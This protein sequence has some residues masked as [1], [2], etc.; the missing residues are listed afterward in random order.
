MRCLKMVGGLVALVAAVL[1]TGELRAVQVLG[2]GTAALLRGDL[3]DIDDDGVETSYFPPDNYGGFD[4]AFF[5]SDEPGFGGG[6]SAFNVFDNVVGGG[7]DKW[8]C[9]TVF[10]QIVGADFRDAQGLAFRLT[11]FTVSSAN[12]TPDRDPRIWRIDGS[13]DGESWCPIFSPAHLADAVDALGLA[14]GSAIW[15]ARGQVILF[16]EGVD[17][18]EQD[19]AYSMFRMVTLKTNLTTGAFFQIS[20]IEFFGEEDEPPV[21][22]PPCEECS[23]PV[24]DVTCE[25]GG[26]GSLS[27]FWDNPENCACADETLLFIK[28]VEVASVEAS[29]TSATIPAGLLPACLFAAVEVRNCSFISAICSPLKV[30]GTGTAALLGD[31]LGGDL[32]DVGNDGVEGSYFPPDNYGG[33]DADFFSSDEPGF[34]GGEFAFNVFDNIVGGGND[35]W[36]CGTVFP[37]IVGADFS[38]TF[39]ATQ[40]RL[41][42]FTVASANDTPDRDPRVWR[43]EGSNDG[44]D[45]TTIFS[46]ECDPTA[47]LWTA[48]NQVILFEE[49]AEYDVQVE[50]YS[51]FRMVVDKTGL[52]G[53]AFFQIAEIEFFGEETEPV[54]PEICNNGVDDDG[55]DLVDCADPEC[56]GTPAC[57]EAKRF[58]R[59]DTDGNGQ[60]IINDGIQILE[61]LFAGRKALDS[62]CE[63]TADV[64]DNGTL[65]IGDPIWLF[66][67]LFA[68]GPN[69]AAPYGGCGPDPTPDDGISCEGYAL[70]K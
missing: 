65:T 61:L 69:P 58:V 21:D 36:C 62:N 2:T 53:G 1:A 11:H 47:S 41:T 22:P 6:E 64:D 4:A 35:K 63:D 54:K 45:W 24:T 15:T 70:C 60:Y 50:G 27:V 28:G 52:T 44:V 17:Y 38:E 46:Q 34:G 32:T 40:F 49:G 68:S 5:S 59:G 23:D 12:D 56:K 10:P 16:E 43:I 9:G 51:M 67:F 18:P 30:L 8:C 66:N 33:F 7:N 14:A 57:P 37:Q 39:P 26:D 25:M 55:D 19:T 13:N 20:E 31:D 42:H 29:K 3:T 48:R